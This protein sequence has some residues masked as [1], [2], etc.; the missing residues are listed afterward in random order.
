MKIFKSFSNDISYEDVL[1]LGGAFAV[2]HINYGK[3]PMFNEFE[4]KAIAEKSRKHS[5]S[6]C[7]LY[8]SILRN[9]AVNV[10]IGEDRNFFAHKMCC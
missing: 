10:R 6:S 2:A 1:Q 3:I 8:T 4:G 7:L 5:I 9:T